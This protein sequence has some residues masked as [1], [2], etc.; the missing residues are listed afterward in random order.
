MVSWVQDDE[1]IAIDASDEMR[2]TLWQCMH[3][4]QKHEDEL[5]GF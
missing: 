3:K 4:H 5:Q 1:E 2:R